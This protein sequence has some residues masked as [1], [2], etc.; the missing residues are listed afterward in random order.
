[1]TGARPRRRSCDVAG[2][3]DAALARRYGPGLLAW[4]RREEQRLADRGIPSDAR[5]LN[6]AAFRAA[7]PERCR[8]SIARWARFVQHLARRGDLLVVQPDLTGM[9]PLS[10][11]VVR[12]GRP[13]ADGRTAASVEDPGDSRLRGREAR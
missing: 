10:Y 1:M 3:R 13:S 5:F 12:L 11:F 2:S 8:P 6:T 7:L 4:C 9:D